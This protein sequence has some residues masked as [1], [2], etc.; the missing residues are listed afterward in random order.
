MSADHTEP[1]WDPNELSSFA[2]D[3][4]SSRRSIAPTPGERDMAAFV[5]DLFITDAEAS[6]ALDRLRYTGGAAA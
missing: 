1:G 4:W 2:A 5:V 6:E 3:L